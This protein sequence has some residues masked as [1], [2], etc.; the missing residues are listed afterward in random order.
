MCVDAFSF[1]LGYAQELAAALIKLQIQ[2]LSSM[3]SFSPLFLP[4]PR[5]MQATLLIYDII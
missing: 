1:Q 2:N 5:D 4:R 3:V